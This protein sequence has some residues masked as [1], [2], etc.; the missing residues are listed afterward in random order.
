VTGTLLDMGCCLVAVASWVSPRLALFVMW[1]F[2]NDRMS[3]AFDSFLIGFLGFLFLPWTALAYVICYAP[4]DLTHARGVQGFGWLVVA[5]AFIV[6]ISS[7]TSGERAR[8]E[9]ARR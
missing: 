6:D 8:R 7:Y 9:R 5:F 4:G 2:F 3:L 1:L